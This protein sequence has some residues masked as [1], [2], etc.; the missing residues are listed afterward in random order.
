M[1]LLENKVL[2]RIFGPKRDEVRGVW[3]KLNNE[4]FH[5][6]Y[7]SPTIVRIIKYRRMKWA[8][9]VALWGRGEVC[10]GFWWGNLRE[11]DY[12]G[13]PDG[14]IILRWIFKKWDVGYGLD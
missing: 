5:D 7:S 4:E 12:L 3:I 2:R 6:L 11:R 10:T 9:H 8:G 1:R 14:R 13:D